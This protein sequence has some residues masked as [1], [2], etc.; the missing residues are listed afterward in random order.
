MNTERTEKFVNAIACDLEEGGFRQVSGTML[1]R[2][3]ATAVSAALPLLAEQQVAELPPLP[4]TQEFTN[5]YGVIRAFSAE[6]MQQYARTALAATGKQQVG[7][8]CQS[9]K[10]SGEGRAITGSGPD[11]YEVDALCSACGGTGAPAQQVG[12]VQGDALAA[13]ETCSGWGRIGGPSFY[14]PDEG[15]DPCPDCNPA[16]R[17]PVGRERVAWASTGATGH[18]VVAMPD[19]HKLPYGDYDLYAAPP[20]QGIDLGQLWEPIKEA[21]H[22]ALSAHMMGISHAKRERVAVYVARLL[23]DAQRD[24]APG[25]VS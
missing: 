16:S 14:A 8:D 1:R 5:L 4:R 22:T 2:T 23:R 19:L 24:A 11:V 18:K 7:D 13:C 10:G 9:C 17:Q 25:V 12:E 3:L 21:V 15:G 6:Q 20:A